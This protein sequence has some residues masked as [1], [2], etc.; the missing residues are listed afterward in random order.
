MCG[1][2]RGVAG[3]RELKMEAGS[4]ADVALHGDLA[5]VFLDDAIGYGEAEA[6]AFALAVAWC[7]LGG[8]E[9]IVDAQHVLGRDAVARICDLQHDALAALAGGHAQGAAAGL[10]ADDGV[11]RVEEE[12]EQHLL[13]LAL[14][15][16]DGG[17]I[18]CQAR[19]HFNLRGLELVLQQGEGV[20]DDAVHIHAGERGAAGAREVEQTV[21]NL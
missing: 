3:Y 15:A 2:G 14:V 5:G 9:G 4:F 19:V 21:H 12:I 6:S 16:V 8:E 7:A 11:L 18:V 17:Q 20:V 13:Q 10:A 1:C